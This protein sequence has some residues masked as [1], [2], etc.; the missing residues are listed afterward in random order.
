[1]GWQSIHVHCTDT[2]QVSEVSASEASRKLMT[3]D[4]DTKSFLTKRDERGFIEKFDE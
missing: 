3:I 2:C 1:L 4:I